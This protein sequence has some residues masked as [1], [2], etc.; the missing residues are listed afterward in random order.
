MFVFSL[1]I[2]QTRIFSL[3][4]QLVFDTESPVSLQILAAHV[5][6]R[7]LTTIPSLI[8]TYHSELKDRQLS[9]SIGTYTSTYFSPPIV[10]SLL[11]SIRSPSTLESLQSEEFK[12]KV[13]GSVREIIAT[14]VVD[15][16]TMEIALS[17]PADYPL[18]AVEVKDI[19][20]VG[21]QETKWRMWLLNVNQ[22]AQVSSLW[23]EF[24]FGGDTYDY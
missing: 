23:V 11:S 20:R 1:F 21:V 22:I 14:Y 16:Q 19:R 8:R 17:V 12:V 10:T 24:L 5:F 18:K 15:D 7:S 3:F 2:S 13:Q 6:Y 4:F 9:S